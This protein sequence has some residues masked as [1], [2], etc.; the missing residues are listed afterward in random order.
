MTDFDHVELAWGVQNAYAYPEAFASFERQTEGKTT[1][2]AG[3]CPY[4]GGR[5]NT[6]IGL[7]V[8]A[9]GDA[10]VRAATGPA[11]QNLLYVPC[12]CLLTHPGR[13]D[14]LAGC[15]GYIPVAPE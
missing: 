8:L 1:G 9:P 6:V 3:S 5:F 12:D 15:G 7:N 13:P 10:D 14:G 2:V 11:Q 4:C